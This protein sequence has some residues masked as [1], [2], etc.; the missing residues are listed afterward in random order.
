[1][2]NCLFG[3]LKLTKNAGQDK[4]KYFGY[5]IRFD[6]S[7]EFSYTHGVVRKNI[8]ILELN[9]NSRSLI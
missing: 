1:M 9:I 6:S 5:C 4:R 7:L 3:S 2:S 8:N